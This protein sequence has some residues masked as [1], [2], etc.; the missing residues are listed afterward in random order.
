MNPTIIEASEKLREI[1]NSF[2]KEDKER[3]AKTA[4]ICGVSIFEVIDVAEKK[5]GSYVR[6]V[7]TLEM[8]IRILESTREELKN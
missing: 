4:K 2:P 7:Y 5:N 6:N 8:A 1:Y 3:R